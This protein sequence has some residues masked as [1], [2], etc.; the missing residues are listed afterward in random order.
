MIERTD[1]ATTVGIHSMEVA[2]YVYSPQI[3]RS[4]VSLFVN[5]SNLSFELELEFPCRVG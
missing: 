2:T 5:A 3:Y 1:F 4:T